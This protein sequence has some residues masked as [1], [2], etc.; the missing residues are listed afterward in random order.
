[1]GS[2]WGSFVCRQKGNLCVSRMFFLEGLPGNITNMT[3]RGGL[4]PAH[5][6]SPRRVGDETRGRAQRGTKAARP[7][8][9]SSQVPLEK[10]E[11]GAERAYLLQKWSLSKGLGSHSSAP[12]SP[13]PPVPEEQ[14]RSR[15][16]LFFPG[17]QMGSPEIVAA[18]MPPWVHQG[19]PHSHPLCCGWMS[20]DR[21]QAVN[22]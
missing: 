13:V 21:N 6:G 3:P 9:Q 4:P 16:G 11:G 17:C 14:L 7:R 19:L 22:S 2:V 5:I 10:T 1:M 18:L 12:C 20:G 15:R 8:R